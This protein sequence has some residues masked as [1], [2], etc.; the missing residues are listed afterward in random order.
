MEAENDKCATVYITGDY[1][2]LKKF[3]RRN[4]K[5][6]RAYID[7][8]TKGAPK[9]YEIGFPV[10]VNEEM[11]VLEGWDRVQALKMMN[12]PISYIIVKEEK[13]ENR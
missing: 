2:K 11:E 13:D 3:K 1:A 9:A 12:Q 4:R 8:V 10:L 5:K 6:G 7:R